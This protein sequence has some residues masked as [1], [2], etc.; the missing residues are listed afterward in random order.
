MAL[1][2][3][4]VSSNK[5]FAGFQKVFSH[6]SASTK[7]E[8]K[9][10]VYL[11]AKAVD[12]TPCPVIY[13]LSGLTCNELNFVQKAGAQKIASELGIILVCP[14]TSPRGCNIAGE[15]DS[16]D[17]GTGAGF[18]VDATEEAWKINYRMFS[19]VTVE[20]PEVVNKNFP[21][22]GKQSIMGHSMGGHGALVCALRTPG[23]YSSVS[24]FA[25]ICAPTECPWGHKAFSGYLG[26]DKA[27]WDEYDACKLVSKYSGPP[28]G[29]LVSQGESDQFLK[30]GQLQPEKLVEACAKS[31]MPVILNRDE[32]YDHSYFYIATFINDHIAHHAKFLFE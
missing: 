10:A 26:A 2:I 28:L 18:Y 27:K 11:P 6:Q 15:D 23:F 12:N 24:A 29:I 22:N 7:C 13:W 31:C 32:G 14:D 4:E 3:K 5:C 19:Y 8:M 17:F 9:F 20:L 1:E 16:W 21:T 30:D 25:P